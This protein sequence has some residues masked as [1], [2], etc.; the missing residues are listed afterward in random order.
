MTVRERTAR[1][2]GEELRQRETTESQ[3]LVLGLLS[4]RIIETVGIFR[5]LPD[6]HRFLLRAAAAFFLPC[7]LFL[8]EDVLYV[9]LDVLVFY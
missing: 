3:R 6:P 5:C 4:V 9:V 7:A 1:S 8:V 2:A